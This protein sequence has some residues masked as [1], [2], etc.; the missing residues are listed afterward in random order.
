[1]N[2]DT[3]NNLFLCGDNQ[4]SIFM[5][6]N[7]IMGKCTKHINIQYHFICDVVLDNKMQLYYIKGSENPADM[8]IKSLGHIKFPKF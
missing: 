1:M 6:S 5:A 8:F 7:P 3:K 4:G 2:L